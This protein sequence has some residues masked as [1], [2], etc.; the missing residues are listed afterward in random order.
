MEQPRGRPDFKGISIKRFMIL[1]SALSES[2]FVSRVA[3]LIEAMVRVPPTSAGSMPLR[4]ESICSGPIRGERE[5][6]F[7]KAP[8][9]YILVCCWPKLGH[10]TTFSS[11]N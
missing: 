1:G 5:N 4:K 9:K 7:T 6:T 2:S 3:A 11:M 8:G 10:V